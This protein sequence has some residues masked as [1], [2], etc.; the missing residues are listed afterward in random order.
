MGART[1]LTAD[2]SDAFYA[3]AFLLFGRAGIGISQFVSVEDF[4]GKSHQL[5]LNTGWKELPSEQFH[6]AKD[7]LVTQEILMERGNNPLSLGSDP[8]DLK[9]SC[10]KKYKH[11]R[12]IGPSEELD[13]DIQ[14]M[15]QHPFCDNTYCHYHFRESNKRGENYTDLN[16]FCAQKFQDAALK[17]ML[18]QEVWQRFLG[19]YTSDRGQLGHIVRGKDPLGGRDFAATEFQGIQSEPARIDYCQRAGVPLFP[20]QIS[21]IRHDRSL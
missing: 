17:L 12:T 3:A 2:E 13:I 18:H 1:E 8:I 5:L 6:I 19:R 16:V 20:V 7:A 11:L 21:A 14:Y 4:I 15:M 9:I 10:N